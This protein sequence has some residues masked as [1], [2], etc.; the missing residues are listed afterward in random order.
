MRKKKERSFLDVD[1]PADR[2]VRFYLDPNDP[3]VIAVEIDVE[4]AGTMR[5]RMGVN[6]AKKLA[7]RLYAVAEEGRWRAADSRPRSDG[8]LA[9]HGRHPVPKTP[10]RSR[11]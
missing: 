9:F 10:V 6:D 8:A 2:G 7:C 1:S 11:R 4:E 5:L 3:D